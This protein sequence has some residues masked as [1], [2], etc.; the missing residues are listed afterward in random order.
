M[1]IKKLIKST[2]ALNKLKQDLKSGEFEAKLMTSPLGKSF[3][4]KWPA[5]QSGEFEIKRR[6]ATMILSPQVGFDKGSTMGEGG[7]AESKND[8]PVAEEKNGSCCDVMAIIE[9]ML[10]YLAIFD[11]ITDMIVGL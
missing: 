7:E 1:S 4:E 6:S 10:E 11:F 5:K 3:N 9:F 2:M 8:K